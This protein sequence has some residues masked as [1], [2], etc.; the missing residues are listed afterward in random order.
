MGVEYLTLLIHKAESQPQTLR[1]RGRKTIMLSVC[2]CPRIANRAEWSRWF[3]F[4]PNP[5]S[6]IGINKHA[7]KRLTYNQLNGITNA[8]KHKTQVP[9]IRLMTVY[10]HPLILTDENLSWPPP[11]PL[12]FTFL[13]YHFPMSCYKHSKAKMGDLLFKHSRRAGCLSLIWRYWSG[14]FGHVL[15]WNLLAFFVN[16]PDVSLA[17]ILSCNFSCLSVHLK[18]NRQ[19]KTKN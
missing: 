17:L 11:S 8:S 5:N 4:L 6:V 13:S 16:I 1:G 2:V 7:S 18:T 12:L 10:C 9:L 14:F 19:T 15:P 3:G